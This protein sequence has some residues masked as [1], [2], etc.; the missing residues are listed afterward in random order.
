MAKLIGGMTI[1]NLCNDMNISRM[2]LNRYRNDEHWPGDDA[3]L[4]YIRAFIV[5]KRPVNGAGRKKKSG[6][7]HGAE[8]RTASG[9][10]ELGG[11]MPHG[12]SGRMI[13]TFGGAVDIGEQLDDEF[14]NLGALLGLDSELKLTV[15]EKNKTQIATYQERFMQEYRDDMRGRINKAFG[16]VIE[17]IK[18]FDLTR[19]QLENLR[20]AFARGMQ[21]LELEPPPEEGEADDNEQMELL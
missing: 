20:K 10:P 21:M 9:T 2:S 7:G 14:N 11:A 3:P 6:M 13:E 12:Q 17:L 4:D 18:G 1:K 15:I 19:A 8:S 16:D 5:A